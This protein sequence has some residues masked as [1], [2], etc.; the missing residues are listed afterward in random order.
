MYL[1]ISLT[2]RLV[3]QNVHPMPVQRRF[4]KT[5]AVLLTLPP[6]DFVQQ[7]QEVDLNFKSNHLIVIV[8]AEL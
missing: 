1:Q 4:N 6:N 8:M 7:H 2:S 3:F 5:Q